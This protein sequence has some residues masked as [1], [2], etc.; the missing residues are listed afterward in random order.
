MAGIASAAPDLLPHSAA[1]RD[2][3][4]LVDCFSQ[5]F[6]TV[7]LLTVGTVVYICHPS[8]SVP[9]ICITSIGPMVPKGEALEPVN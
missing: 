8:F 1:S 9:F 6:H 2:Y 4:C 3:H 7:F 5:V